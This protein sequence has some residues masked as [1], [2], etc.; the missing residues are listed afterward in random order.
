MTV[1]CPLDCEFLQ[2]ARKHEKREPFHPEELPNPDI[3][4]PRKFLQDNHDLLVFLGRALALLA[5]GASEAVDFDVREALDA[6]IRTYRTLQNGVYYET[7]PQNILA[8]NVYRIV[9][10]G[11]AQF[12]QKERER[13]GMSKTRDADVIGLLVYLQRLELSRNNGRRRGRAFLG[14]L[15]EYYGAVPEPAAPPPSSLILP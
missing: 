2:E 12:R 6:L 1:T 5:G 14:A 4:L 8:M 15:S 13:L 11:L 9:Q 3:R 10:H 7:L